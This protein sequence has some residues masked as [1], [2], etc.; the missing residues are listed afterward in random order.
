MFEAGRVFA[1]DDGVLGIDTGFEGVGTG[2]GF[3]FGGAGPGG[4]ARVGAVGCD[5]AEGGHGDPFKGYK[6]KRQARDGGLPG[7]ELPK[8][9]LAWRIGEGGD[10]RGEVVDGK[11]EI[12]SSF[13][14]WGFGFG[15]QMNADERG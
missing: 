4:F 9:N 13:V 1:D 6:Q 8:T 7:E 3:S 14:N 2:D 11:G 10:Q 12:K 15:P 5:L